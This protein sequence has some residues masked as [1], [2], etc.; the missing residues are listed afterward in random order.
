MR[1]VVPS[2]GILLNQSSGAPSFKRLRKAEAAS[3]YSMVLDEHLSFVRRLPWT[4]LDRV[5]S[6]VGEPLMEKYQL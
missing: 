5:V 4:L 6:R 2:E 3:E 1:W